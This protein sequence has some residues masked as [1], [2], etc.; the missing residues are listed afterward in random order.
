MFILLGMIVYLAI[1]WPL[2]SRA[3]SDTTI[4][5]VDPTKLDTARGTA[6][7]SFIL[8]R[9]G[10]LGRLARNLL[11]DTGS[12]YTGPVKNDIVFSIYEGR[13]IR[14]ITVQGVDFGTAISDT[15]KK[16]KNTLTNLANSFHHKTRG[17]AVRNNL[18]FQ[19]GDRVQPYL[20]ADN[21][22]HLRDQPYLQDARIVVRSS[23][24]S[25]DSVDITVLTKDVLSIGGSFRMHNST[26][27]SGSVREDNLG[28][29]GDRLQ[30][31]L[32]YD[33]RRKEKVGYGGEMIKRN[34]LGS[35]IDGYAGFQN[36]ADAFNSGRD[37]ETTYYGRLIRPLV[38]PYI[39]LTYAVE[40]AYHRTDN[41]YLD[42][43]TY[44]SDARYRYFNY[45]SW[46][47]W[48]TGAYSIGKGNEDGRL[49]TLVGLRYFKK[50]FQEV[51]AFFSEEFYYDYQDMEAVLGSV[52]IFR[53]DFYKTHYVYGFGRSEDVPEGRDITLTAGWTKKQ[54]QERPYMGLDFQRFYFTSKEAYYNFTGRIGG[55]YHKGKIEDMD[56]LVNLDYFSKLQTLSSKWK[57]RSFVSAG[58]TTQV[59]KEL[60]APLFLESNFG[61]PELHNGKRIVGEVRSTL[62]AESVFFSPWTFINFKFAPFVF[63]NLTLL[64]PDKQDLK[65]SD[66]YSSIGGGLRSRNES[67]IFGTLELKGYF[68][69]RKSFYGKWYRVELNTNVK[70]K[71]N[72]QFIKRPEIIL[73]N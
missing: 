25:F 55:Y 49:R 5:K 14:S 15:T 66:L 47:G 43:S 71:Y 69:P 60:N 19:V 35:F 45:D 52:S 61:L 42:D 39:K 65:K 6:M 40:A 21:E 27:V 17:W 32:L 10:L 64:T 62:K 44:K 8:K 57:Q 18:F 31:S 56:I 50:Q 67:L 53:Q 11:T 70:F 7:D 73:A 13:I 20:L 29:W 63:G 3:Q 22:R 34:I 2:S 23:D 46:I 30:G 48:N 16:F 68:F 1:A 59:H 28:G 12:T 72:R 24:K 4:R 26:S 54:G 41:M 9:R 37:E 51:P 58:I 36:F 38:N 33:Q